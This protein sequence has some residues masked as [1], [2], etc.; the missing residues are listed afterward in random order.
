MKDAKD[1]GRGARKPGKDGARIEG[2]E[3]ESRKAGRR[4]RCGAKVESGA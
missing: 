2:T 3:G 4:G 1:E